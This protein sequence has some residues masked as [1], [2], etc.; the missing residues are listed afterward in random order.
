M[1]GEPSETL[2]RAGRG[3]APR[4]LPL[5]GLKGLFI[6]PVVLS[7][8]YV[9]SHLNDL[10]L[11]R[12]GG[13]F[14]DAFLV[15]AGYL[16][17]RSARSRRDSGL[18]LPR[19]VQDRVAV[20]WP[21]PVLVLVGLAAFE[22][23]YALYGNSFYFQG[24]APFSQWTSI[25]YLPA[26]IGLVEA[27]VH[28]G[29]VHWNPATWSVGLIA[30]LSFLIGVVVYA[31]RRA[32]GIFL[33]LIAL[34]APLFLALSGLEG[35]AGLT[36]PPLRA[37]YAAAL[38]AT[39]AAFLPRAD[40]RALDLDPLLLGLL[41]GGALLGF[42]AFMAVL[43]SG[44]S[45]LLVAPAALGVIWLF[46]RPGGIVAGWL[47]LPFPVVLGRCSLALFTVMVFV[48]LRVREVADLMALTFGKPA[49]SFPLN[50]PGEPVHGSLFPM[51]GATPWQGDAF[52]V[53]M[54][55]VAFL[56]ARALTDHLLLPLRQR[57]R[58]A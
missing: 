12:Q 25:D 52:V 48:Q 9:N 37:L 39:G 23:A 13:L 49:F 46:A 5:D 53:I 47:A 41:Q 8:L 58:R 11:V 35:D 57:L 43:P 34:A 19:Y 55:G 4:H 26:Q 51:L 6:L 42:L 32:G 28:D 10:F 2:P 54:L 18:S 38:G 36:P 56:I 50:A 45:T 3:T 30:W 40:G 44:L 22:G 16:F 7:M 21:V 1:T 15:L 20:F 24:R 31:V 17:Y 29:P 14:L 33:A 27:F